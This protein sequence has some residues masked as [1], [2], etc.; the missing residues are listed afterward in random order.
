MPGD[1][2][3]DQAAN[4]PLTTIEGEAKLRD[5]LAKKV[6]FVAVTPHPL[7]FQDPGF[8]PLR[9]GMAVRTLRG[10]HSVILTSLTLVKDADAVKLSMHGRKESV[11]ANVKLSLDKEGLAVLGCAS[12]EGHGPCD[13]TISPVAPSGAADPGRL[14]F[15][16]APAGGDLLTVSSVTSAG[17]ADPDLETL[18]VI[19]GRL[20]S[21]TPLFDREGKVAAVVVRP[22]FGDLNRSLATRLAPPGKPL[23][24][25]KADK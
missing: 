16:L 21:G 4:N 5:L 13:A 12:G 14:L 3:A 1:L 23:S 8:L 25:K 10:G 7:E 9:F 6:I 18:I 15:F 19:N 22:T 24:G 11:N 17:N 2:F 20:P